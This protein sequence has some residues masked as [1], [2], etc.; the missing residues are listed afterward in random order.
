MSS[1]PATGGC[2]G[3]FRRGTGLEA[4]G[5]LCPQAAFLEGRARNLPVLDRKGSKMPS[6]DMDLDDVHSLCSDRVPI[7][8]KIR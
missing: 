4:P 7:L 8:V 3:S 1:L 2:R 6:L 5:Y